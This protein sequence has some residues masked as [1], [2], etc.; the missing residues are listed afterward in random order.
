[1]FETEPR[2]NKYSVD[3]VRGGEVFDSTL[4]NAF[5]DYLI[6]LASGRKEVQ[7]TIGY[8]ALNKIRMFYG[9]WQC[10]FRL[11]VHYLQYFM[12]S[13]PIRGS[14]EAASN[15]IAMTSSPSNGFLAEPGVVTFS[16]A[17]DYEHLVTQFDPDAL[18][19]IIS[20]LA[21]TPTVGQLKLDRSCFGA[22]REARLSQNLVKL[23]V[24]ELDAEDSIPSPVVIAEL[25]QA[26]FVAFLCGNRHNYSKLLD[27]RAKCGGPWQV[28]RVEEYIE[29]NWDQPIAIEA[30]AVVANTSARSIFHSFREHRCCSPM[31]FVKHVRLKHANE[32]LSARACETS[33]TS[34]AF[35]CGFGNL[36]HFA[37]DYKRAF[38]EMPSETLARAKGGV[39]S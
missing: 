9:H 24:D 2:L 15:G 36:G 17:S 28:R 20:A 7:A 30:L 16:P 27:G 25:E 21:G 3:G 1:M 31:N 14:C 11:Q 23:L 13:F 8:C 10:S 38:G 29:A 6:E 32:M 26:I 35:A 5:P 37:N 34:V 22:R 39:R 18:L 4:A 33:V 19:K 12:Q